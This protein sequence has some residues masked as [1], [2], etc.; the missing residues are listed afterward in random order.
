MR[1][2]FCS[3]FLGICLF[4]PLKAQERLSEVKFETAQEKAAAGNYEASIAL[5]QELSKDFPG[6]YDYQLYLARVYSWNRDYPEAILI[7]ESMMKE[8]DYNPELMQLMV[9]MQLWAG[10]HREVVSYSDK[11]LQKEDNHFY[12]IQKATAH[13]ELKEEKQALQTLEAVLQE[14]P[15]HREALYLQTQILKR[16][17]QHLSLSYLNTS[18]SGPSAAPRHLGY[19]EYKRN[20]GSVP[21]LARLNKGHLHG[22]TGSL[23]EV[24][25]YPKV[26]ASS[27]LFLNAGAALDADIFPH[28]KAGAEYYMALKNRMGLSLGSRYLQFEEEEVLMFTGELSYHTQND[29]KFSYRPYLSQSSEKWF[30]SHALALKLTDPL[31][32][33]FWQLDLQYGSVPYAYYTS[34][35]FS[36]LSA[37]RMGLQHQ[38]RLAGSFLVQ[39][40]AMYEYEEYLPSEF[41]NRFNLQLITT[42]R[43]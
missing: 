1:K 16:K 12:R 41:R 6:N 24:D 3:L 31:K 26:S 27:Y 15:Q 37:F 36:D 13:M 20:L 39:P 28:F 19:L 29:M 25:A 30:L 33:S 5:L 38:F 8:G 32:E 23:F 34:S 42:F 10:N 9:S 22:Q 21:M 2:L 43:F 7:L 17:T 40:V 35:D 4:G 14:E 18:F 11:A